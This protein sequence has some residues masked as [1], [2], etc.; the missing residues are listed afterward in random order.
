MQHFTGSWVYL[1]IASQ[2]G[3][4][5]SRLLTTNIVIIVGQRKLK[6][7]FLG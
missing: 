1:E 5:C 2:L 3:L 4:R 7:I 6:K